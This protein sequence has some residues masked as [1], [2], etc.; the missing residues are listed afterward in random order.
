[1]DDTLN[2]VVVLTDAQSSEGSVPRTINHKPRSHVTFKGGQARLAHRWFRLTPSF[3]P[4]LV[5]TVLEAHGGTDPRVYDPFSGRGTTPIECQ[6]LGVPSIGVEINPALYFAGVTSLAWDVDPASLRH[7]L[8]NILELTKRLRED[9]KDRSLEDVAN[10]LAFRVPSIHN[11]YRWW[12][13]EVLRDLLLLRYAIHSER[14][15]H[16]ERDLLLLGLMNILLD[17]ANITLG[18]LQLHFVDRAEEVIDAL[19]L[20]ARS[21]EVMIEDLGELSTLPP[22]NRS[23]I[24]LGDNRTPPPEVGRFRPNIVITSPPYPN[25]YSYVWNTRPHLY[26]MDWFTQPSEAAALDSATVGGTWGIATSRHQKGQYRYSRSC[27]EEIATPVVEVIRRSDNLMANYVAMYLDDLH[28]G[29][30]A[31]AAVLDQ[32]ALCA[33]VVGNSRMKGTIVETDVLLAQLFESAGYE[34]LGNEEVR[35]RNSGKEL[36]ETIVYAKFRGQPVTRDRT[37]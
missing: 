24:Y 32:G 2:D 17:A 37:A 28:K 16:R 27:V 5:R 34:A 20:F 4:T 9:H 3:S 36:H 22:I 7:A 33:Y 35:R 25:R 31:N 29:L 11:V 19:S 8:P 1:M 30:V 10:L 21:I 26:F 14:L 15:D 12:R 6:L 18:R 23:K 13:P